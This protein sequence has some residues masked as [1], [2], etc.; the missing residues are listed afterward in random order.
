MCPVCLFKV[1]Y[2]TFKIDGPCISGIVFYK[3]NG[4]L[5]FKEEFVK[6]VLHYANAHGFYCEAPSA[7]SHVVS[8]LIGLVAC[9]EQVVDFRRHADTRLVYKEVVEQNLGTIVP[10]FEQFER[11]GQFHF[12]V[13]YI[14]ALPC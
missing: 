8:I 7:D 13:T 11:F 3:R 6:R 14:Y 4:A 2:V 9:T 1:V 5:S 10:T 12:H